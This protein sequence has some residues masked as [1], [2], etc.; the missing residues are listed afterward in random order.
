MMDY[1]SFINNSVSIFFYIYINNSLGGYKTYMSLSV[2]TTY[3]NWLLGTSLGLALWYRN[4]GPDREIGGFLIS[5]SLMFLLEYGAANLM[6]KEQ[7]AYFLQ[8]A[9]MLS[10]FIFAL[11]ISYKTGN[12]AGKIF[13]IVTLILLAFALFCGSDVANMAEISFFNWG[14]NPVLMSIFVIAMYLMIGYSSIYNESYILAIV[15]ILTIV[16]IFVVLSLYP[17]EQ[18]GYYFMLVML[19]GFMIYW[20]APFFTEQFHKSLIQM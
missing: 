11:L 13:V 18:F 1:L 5:L 15:A 3:L 8:A 2:R 10:L 14:I 4:V 19:A 6:K 16:S 17:S 9:L 7:V 12:A 20:M